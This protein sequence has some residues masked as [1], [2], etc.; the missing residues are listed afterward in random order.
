MRLRY[1]RVVGDPTEPVL[2]PPDEDVRKR[3][4]AQKRSSTAPELRLRQ[5][6]HQ[7][8]LRYR[9]GLKVPSLPRRT[10]DIAF[11]RAKVAVFVDGCFWHMCPVHYIAPKSNSQWWAAKIESNC[12]RDRD[13]DAVLRNSGWTV[14]RIWEH[15]PTADGA[16]LVQETLFNHSARES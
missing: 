5:E 3:M 8:G 1:R 6:L 4:R 16:T 7:R 15:T 11:T 13:T 10:I 12:A 14:V 2:V 9:V